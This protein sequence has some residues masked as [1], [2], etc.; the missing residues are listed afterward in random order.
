MCVY[1]GNAKHGIIE[2]FLI[3]ELLSRSLHKGWAVT[4]FVCVRPNVSPLLKMSFESTFDFLRNACLHRESDPIDSS[5]AQLVVG[6]PT[7]GGTG[8]FSLRNT[9]IGLAN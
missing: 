7:H 6:C 9:L 3:H 2:S 5:S 8:A 1:I 4:L